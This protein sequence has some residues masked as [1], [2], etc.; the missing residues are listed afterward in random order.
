MPRAPHG[1]G[2]MPL[3]DTE[4]SGAPTERH[5]QK[6]APNLSFDLCPYLVR[7]L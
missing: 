3:G 1:D 7:P 4:R 2:A 5:L 6:H